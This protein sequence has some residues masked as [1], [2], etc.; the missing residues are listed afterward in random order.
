[1]QMDVMQDHRKQDP[2]RLWGDKHTQDIVSPS[3]NRYMETLQC[4]VRC[5]CPGFF[6][7]N[8][9]EAKQKN[10]PGKEKSLLSTVRA[11]DCSFTTSMDCPMCTVDG[12]LPKVPRTNSATSCTVNMCSSS[13]KMAGKEF[14]RAA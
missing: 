13:S 3:H 2:S 6:H 9:Q 12:M 1:M 7:I 8:D 4:E 11:M 5:V 14:S 10:L